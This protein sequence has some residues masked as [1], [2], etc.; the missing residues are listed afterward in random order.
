MII[1][2]TPNSPGGQVYVVTLVWVLSG[3]IAIGVA[4][5]L[6]GKYRVDLNLAK[7]RGHSAVRRSVSERAIEST[8]L[9]ALIGVLVTVVGA[10]ALIVS[11]TTLTDLPDLEFDI[12][13]WGLVMIPWVLILDMVREYRHQLRLLKGDAPQAVP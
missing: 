1:D 7:R 13:L 5:M 10:R 11:Y 6:F 12:V 4:A 2:L 8:A 9:H 3:L